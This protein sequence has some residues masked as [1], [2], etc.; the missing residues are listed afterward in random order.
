MFT[1]YDY[2]SVL[3]DLKKIK[4]SL[5]YQETYSKPLPLQDS[6]ISGNQL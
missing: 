2:N 6:S 3:N 1:K 5:G 4:Q